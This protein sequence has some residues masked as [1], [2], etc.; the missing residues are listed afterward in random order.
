MLHFANIDRDKYFIPVSKEGKY[1]LVFSSTE[2]SISNGN[3]TAARKKGSSC[4]IRVQLPALSARIWQFIPFT[5][6]EKAEISRREEE[7][8][9]KRR[10]EA[11]ARKKLKEERIRLRLSYRDELKAKIAAAEA[12]IRAGLEKK[13]KETK[14]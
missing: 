8:E 13:S 1:R 10:E 12:G 11:E 5:A 9:R 2:G 4:A 14:K 3:V 7:R 6:E